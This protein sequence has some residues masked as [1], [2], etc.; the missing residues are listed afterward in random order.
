MIRAAAGVQLAQ[1]RPTNTS[2]ATLYT[3][4]SGIKIEVTR[5][6]I[7]NTTGSAAAA[8]LFHDDD[9][10]TYDQTTALRYAKSVPANDSIELEFEIGS[11]LFVSAGGSLGIQSG[12]GSAL[13][14][15]LYGVPESTSL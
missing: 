9:G 7:C 4:P 12:T 11:G 2:T 14:Y 6:V 3:A 1:A 15:T 10:T 5:V 13:T 8:S